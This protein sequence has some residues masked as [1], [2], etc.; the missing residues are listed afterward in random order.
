[1]EL[2]S[3][4]KLL[5]ALLCSYLLSAVLLLATGFFPLSFP[6]KGKPDQTGSCRHLRVIRC[7][8]WFFLRPHHR[9]TSFLLRTCCRTFLLSDPGS[10]LFLSRERIHCVH[11]TSSDHHG[12]VYRRRHIRSSH[13]LTAFIFLILSRFFL[14]LLFRKNDLH[15]VDPVLVHLS[16]HKADSVIGNLLALFWQMV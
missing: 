11:A 16:H 6:F 15:P 7:S 10:S 2:F 12:D 3:P 4:K 8:G 14:F 13:Q 5:Q 1:M 9:K